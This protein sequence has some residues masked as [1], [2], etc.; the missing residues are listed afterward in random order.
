M[1]FFE[2]C[3]L[4]DTKTT[5]TKTTRFTSDETIQK[6]ILDHLQIVKFCK[7]SKMKNDDKYWKKKNNITT[8]AI[9]TSS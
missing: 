7:T 8:P 5:M 1:L 9:P 4:A 3:L 6:V 2:V